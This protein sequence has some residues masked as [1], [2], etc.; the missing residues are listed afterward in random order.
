MNTAETI[1]G[2]N[3]ET[4]LERSL[5]IERPQRKVALPTLEG[6]YFEKVKEIIRLE[7]NG[8]YTFIHLINNR[9]ILVSKTLAEIENKLHN[10][11][12]FVRIHRSNTIN[13]DLLIKYVRGKGGYIEMENGVKT[14]VPIAR[15]QGFLSTL[16]R[17]FG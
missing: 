8:N 4:A 5:R 10:H 3:S 12:R 6:I 14:S 2:L 13:L 7:A 1:R 17:Y 16:E 11:P 15:K 9:K